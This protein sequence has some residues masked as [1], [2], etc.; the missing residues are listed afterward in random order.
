MGENYLRECRE[1]GV[2]ILRVRLKVTGLLTEYFPAGKGV[3]PILLSCPATI[4]EI[5]QQI[6]VS[7]ELVMTVL[8]NGQRSDMAYI[9]KEDDEIVLISPVA[10]G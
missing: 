7:H 8:V 4:K 3:L 10:G 1:K 5:L 6:G 9:P 2:E